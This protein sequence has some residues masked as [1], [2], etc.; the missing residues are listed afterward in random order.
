[1]QQVARD[2]GQHPQR[3]EHADQRLSPANLDQI[4]V[5]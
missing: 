3:P 1:V 5:H 2:L 4:D